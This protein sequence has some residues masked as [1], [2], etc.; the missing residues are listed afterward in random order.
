LQSFDP[1]IFN[2]DAIYGTGT[3]LRCGRRLRNL[4]LRIS[5]QA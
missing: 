1:N 4:N 2:D 5:G 3:R